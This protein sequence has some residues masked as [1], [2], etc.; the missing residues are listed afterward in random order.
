MNVSCRRSVIN[1][2]YTLPPGSLS[3]SLV[4][5]NR[6]FNGKPIAIGALLLTLVALTAACGSSGE[7]PTQA[8]NGRATVAPKSSTVPTVTAGTSEAVA[9]RELNTL[10]QMAQG[11]MALDTQALTAY[12]EE[13]GAVLDRIDSDPDVLESFKK[14][15]E[16]ALGVTFVFDGAAGLDREPPTKV[17]LTAPLFTPVHGPFNSLPTDPNYEPYFE[18]KAWLYLRCF[19]DALVDLVVPV[20]A[21]DPIFATE[22]P[23]LFVRSQISNRCINDI[24]RCAR[25]DNPVLNKFQQGDFV[26]AHKTVRSLTTTPEPTPSPTQAP[27]RTPTEIPTQAPPP[28]ATLPPPIAPEP[29]EIPIPQSDGSAFSGTWVGRYT[30]IYTHG[31]S[32][33]GETIPIDGSITATL[34]QTGTLVT[35]TVTL[36]GSDVLELTQDQYGNCNISGRADETTPIS[37][38]ALGNA[39]ASPA[40]LPVAFTL[41]KISDNSAEGRTKNAYL[42]ATLFFGRLR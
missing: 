4:A 6:L 14:L 25:G 18:S 36:G 1:N 23:E 2:G 27:T 20:S 13:V 39:L 26:G 15:L 17:G 40:G 37:A 19:M 29:T 31:F 28:T 24:D 5:A 8:A 34:I 32:I 42:D 21:A 16:D 38:N 7:D 10:I 33:C 41:T 22:V 35:G 30:G 12:S 3:K 9:E 11:E